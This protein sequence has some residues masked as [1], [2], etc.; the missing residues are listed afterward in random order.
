MVCPSNVEELEAALPAIVA[1][2]SPCYV[3]YNPLPVTVP[4]RTPFALGRAEVIA[5][6]GPGGV[7]LLTYGFLLREAARAREILE[8][9]GIPVRLVDLRTLSPVDEEAIVASALSADLLVTIED[10]FAW[11]GLYSLVA[12]AL[13]RHG[14]A[15]R[16]H[17]ICLG[18]RWFLP[19]LLPQVLEHEGFT[20]ERLAER[21]SRALTRPGRM[22]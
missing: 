16:V 13:L 5:E 10:H 1:S 15:C 4:H 3:R 7:A 14:I 9:Q 22:R 2:P 18:E 11:G 17:P 21:I 12:E 8:A 6:G 19:A 20:G